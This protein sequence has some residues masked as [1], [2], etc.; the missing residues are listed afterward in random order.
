MVFEIAI[1]RGQTSCAVF[2]YQTSVY[3]VTVLLFN[4][5][6][7]PPC[8]IVVVDMVS[9]TNSKGVYYVFPYFWHIYNVTSVNEVNIC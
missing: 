4:I 8:S 1:V 7:K 3:N 5:I 2:L 6:L 9:A